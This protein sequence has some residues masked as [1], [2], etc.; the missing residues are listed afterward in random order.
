M[1]SRVR[2]SPCP[3]FMCI[4]ELAFCITERIRMILIFY[5]I[6]LI[7]AFLVVL[8]RNPI[9][10]VL[11]LIV[12]FFN[13]S[14]LFLCMEVEFLAL[15][16]L[17]VYIGAIAV[18]FLFVVMMLN[19]AQ[20][21][22]VGKSSLFGRYT[23]F[24]DAA[25]FVAIGVFI[26]SLLK[27]PDLIF[28]FSTVPIFLANS[29]FLYSDYSNFIGHLHNIQYLAQALYTYNFFSF[30]LVA[31]VLLVAMVGSIALTMHHR[32]DMR[33]QFI[34]EQVEQTY[35]RSIRLVNTKI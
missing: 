27:G 20:P 16:F 18:L 35:F 21:V 1:R 12:V 28:T 4:F 25:L 11:A 8:L 17:I 15:I 19:V 5:F 7:P 26:A 9:H 2:I 31:L 34:F 33:R 3:A 13:L 24:F 10:S 23:L 14:V 6:I 29:D 32:A 30:F 22:S